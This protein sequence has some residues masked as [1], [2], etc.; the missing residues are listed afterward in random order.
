MNLEAVL[1]GIT[2][3][4]YLTLLFTGRQRLEFG[5]YFQAFASL[6][7]LAILGA[8]VFLLGWPGVFIL[9]G[10][11][12]AAAAVRA[13]ML[14]AEQEALLVSA[15]IHGAFRSREEAMAFPKELRASH[16]ALRSIG[17]I[18]LAT[19]IDRLAIRGR[20][21][22]EIRSMAAPITM[23]HIAFKSELVPL[24]D[25]FDRLL[26]LW[27]K[28]ADEAT[29]VADVLTAGTQA[30]AITFDEMLDSMIAV[31]DPVA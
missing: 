25:R 20:R 18:E 23:L 24:V 11:T 21:A 13:V 1:S 16:R 5:R 19:L 12:V 27:G 4:L 10:V 31:A 2:I 17:P 14:A 26:R 28:P 7:G 15:Q 6:A 29:N 22:D 8:S 3:V 9:V 30:S